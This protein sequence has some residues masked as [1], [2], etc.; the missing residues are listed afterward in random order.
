MNVYN[1]NDG[2]GFGWPDMSWV[3][4]SPNMP[5]LSTARSYCGTVLFEGTNLSEGRGTT[6]P[7]ECFGAP[8][9][10]IEKI[11]GVMEKMAPQWMQGCLLRPSFFEPT[12]H[13]FKGELVSAL[14]IH[15]D[16][17]S[18]HPKEFKPYRL[19]TLFLKAAHVVHPKLELWR[20]PPYEYEAKLMPIDILSGHDQLRAWVADDKPRVDDW[21]DS[22]LKDEKA[23]EKE[24]KPYLLY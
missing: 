10:E 8:G 20:Q 23:W 17:P 3:N 14:H 19:A 12:F 13:K 7:L 15:C 1:P 24:R 9:M 5:R 22:L 2:P 4:P 21:H 18:Y 11:L 16:G 6:V